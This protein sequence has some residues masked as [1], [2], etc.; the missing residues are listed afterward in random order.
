MSKISEEYY[1]SYLQVLPQ[2]CEIVQP[3]L[4]VS[5]DY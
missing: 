2:Q 5:Q 1:H 3:G 4:P